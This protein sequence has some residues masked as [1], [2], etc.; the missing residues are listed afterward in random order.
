ML[1]VSPYPDAPPHTAVPQ[2][3]PPLPLDSLPNHLRPISSNVVR[4]S[5]SNPAVSITAVAT[6]VGWSTL[7]GIGVLGFLLSYAMPKGPAPEPTPIIAETVA[8]E[9]TPTQDLTVA[10]ATP[11]ITLSEPPPTPIPTTPPAPPALTPLAAVAEPS[12][13]IQFP[14]PVTGPT[15]VV[16]AS[17]ADYAAPPATAGQIERPTVLTFGRGEGKQPAP[18]YPLRAYQE[19]QEGVVR[20]RFAVS[21]NGRVMSAEAAG[22][23]PWPLLNEEAVRAIRERWRFESGSPRLYEVSIRFQL[24]K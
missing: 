9:L 12:A 21:E 14:L 13:E 22:P 5:P 19:G 7:L 11:D 1:T 24:E 3:P 18:N 6:L 20:V 15:Q 8:V 17:S 2:S 4:F 10:D 23:S 16:D